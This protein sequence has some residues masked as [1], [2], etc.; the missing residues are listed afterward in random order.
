[1]VKRPSVG[2]ELHHLDVDKTIT[3]DPGDHS[4]RRTL[5]MVKKYNS[6]GFTL[7][8]SYPRAAIL[9]CSNIKHSNSKAHC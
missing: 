6:W 7:Q 9:L 8:V 5:K 1:M 2:A 3:T 4:K